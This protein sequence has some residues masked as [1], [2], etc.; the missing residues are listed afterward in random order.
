MSKSD[1]KM[2]F[3]RQLRYEKQCRENWKENAAQKQEKIREYVQSTRALKKSRDHWKTKA[4]E[5]QQRVKDL[6]KRVQQLERKL[7]D[8]SSPPCL[9]T[10]QQDS[11]INNTSQTHDDDDDDDDDNDDSI[12]YHHYSLSTISL[13]VQQVIYVGHSYRSTA[14]SLRFLPSFSYPYSPDHTTIKSWIERIGLYELQRPKEKRDDWIF[15]VDLTLELGQ[16]KALVIYGVPYHYWETCVRSNYLA[17]QYTD[18]QILAL[19]ITTQAT[20][21]WIQS[22]LTQVSSQV[23]VPLQIISD[24]GSNLKKGIQLFQQQHPQLIYTYDVTHAMAKLLEKELFSDDTFPN[25]LSDCHQCL[26]QVQQTEFA[27]ASPPS[28]RSKC[29]FFNLDPLLKWANT[30]LSLPVNLFLQLLPNYNL[31]QTY[32]RFFDKFSWILSYR[33]H[34]LKWSTLLQMTRSLEALLKRAGLSSSSVRLFQN[35]LSSLDIPS[36][37]LPFQ[38]QLFQYL[39]TQLLEV[40]NSP[41]PPH[42]LLASS[43]ILES[44]FG[45]YKHFSK[46]CPLKEL[47]SLLLTIPLS[48]VH[49]TKQ[50]IQDALTTVSSS[51][52]SLW[53]HRTFGQSMLS[54]RKALFS[55]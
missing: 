53:V 54:K 18:G 44:L 30:L 47:R 32:R 20:G 8:A 19:E 35:S 38:H 43:D 55:F 49:L 52:L 40:H 16:E 6:E 5:A 24:H 3:S 48:T 17:L 23:G 7:A 41:S 14:K 25:F 27:F 33:S 21:D 22:I 2:P 37:L 12:P 10:S 1:S 36:S 28:Q 29:R 15:L 9:S 46:R 31:F 4:K 50:Y 13:V 26:L 11:S 39:D 51:D 42:A 45:R 34:I